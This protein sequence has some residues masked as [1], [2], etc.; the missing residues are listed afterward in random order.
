MERT[1]QYQAIGV[2][3]T[4]SL[5]HKTDEDILKDFSRKKAV[6]MNTGKMKQFS[7]PLDEASSPPTSH[8]ALRSTS[9]LPSSPP[10]LPR[11]D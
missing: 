6:L 1:K 7:P 8:P 2:A 9:Y 5:L 11:A 10:G 4:V 3:E